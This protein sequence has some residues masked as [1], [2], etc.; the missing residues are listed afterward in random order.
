MRLKIYKKGEVIKTYEA[1]TYD[2]MFS[3]AE[4]I[5]NLIDL[6]IIQKG[7]NA[8]LV[9][10]VGKVVINSMDKVKDLLKDIFAGITDE[11]LK[12]TKLKEIVAV[13]IEVGKYTVKEIQEVAKQKN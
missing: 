5:S 4:D 8:E 9:K 1:D 13:F 7:D 10:L 6:D 3:V 2:L 12:N 11:E